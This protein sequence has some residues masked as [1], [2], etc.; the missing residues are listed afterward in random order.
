[1]WYCCPAC[2]SEQSKETKSVWNDRERR[3]VGLETYM[4]W[5]TEGRAP[6]PTLTIVLCPTHA[7]SD[8]FPGEALFEERLKDELGDFLDKTEKPA[9]GIIDN[10]LRG[11]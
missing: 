2:C 9:G 6:Q 10:E 7:A 5:D 3:R 11:G 8:Y 4:K 1:M